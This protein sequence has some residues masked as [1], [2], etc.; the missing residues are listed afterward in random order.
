MY[1]EK[2]TQINTVT[3]QIIIYRHLIVFGGDD[4]KTVVVAGYGDLCPAVINN[5]LFIVYMVAVLGS[6]SAIG[7]CRGTM[8]FY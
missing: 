5:K 3:T 8:K 1:L 2:C 4:D 6:N 7:V